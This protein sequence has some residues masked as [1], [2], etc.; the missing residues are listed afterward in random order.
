ME[1][2]RRRFP[3]VD[4]AQFARDLSVAQRDAAKLEPKIDQLVSDPAARR[5]RPRKVTKPRW[6][7]GFDLAMGRALAVKVRTEGYNAMLA[8]AKQGLKFKDPRNDT[9][10]L[11][12][13]REVTVNSALAKDAADATAYLE[14]V[15][16]EHKG[17]PWAMDA[18]RELSSRSA[19]NGASDSR[20]SP[21]ASPKP[22]EWPKTATAAAA[23]RRP[24]GQTAPRPA[25]TLTS[26]DLSAASIYRFASASIANCAVR[27]VLVEMLGDPRRHDV[28]NSRSNCCSGLSCAGMP[29]LVG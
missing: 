3:K 1:N 22:S 27:V 23:A 12:P 28:T 7:A 9:W 19:G 29:L 21:P 16:A 5:T 8:A 20:T 26:T 11:R 17:T 14:R 10:V 15:V 2:V 6:Q 13:S 18:Q 24:A 4:D 25:G